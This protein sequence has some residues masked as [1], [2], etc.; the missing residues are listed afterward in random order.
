MKYN[1]NQPSL[2]YTPPTWVMNAQATRIDGL[3][4]GMVTIEVYDKW[5]DEFRTKC[6]LAWG[7]PE[8]A[9]ILWFRTVG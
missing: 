9:K 4:Q 8:G 5:V 3:K 1:Q 6:C 2:F 7:M